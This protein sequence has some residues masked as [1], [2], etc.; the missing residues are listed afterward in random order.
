MW[1]MLAER[2]PRLYHGLDQV[3]VLSHSTFLAGLKSYHEKII[4]RV[5][6]G[7]PMTRQHRHTVSPEIEDICD[8]G[9]EIQDIEHLLLRC[10]NVDPPPTELLALNSM[11]TCVRSALILPLDHAWHWKSIWKMACYRI[12]AILAKPHMK[13]DLPARDTWDRR[14]HLPAI[15]HCGLY[16]YCSLCHISRRIRDLKF[17]A[18]SA[19][20]KSS[21]VPILEG[22]YR[23]QGAHI[24]RLTLVTWKRHSLRPQYCCVLCRKIW[25][26]TGQAPTA[27]LGT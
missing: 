27:C 12:I 26:A 1:K 15:S 14:G 2:R 8:C 10:P 21:E 11:P 23:R 3:D 19:C 9:L 16:A 18:S 13:T 20:C 22:D 24:A 4:L 5:W 25:W 7:M 17:I 6:A